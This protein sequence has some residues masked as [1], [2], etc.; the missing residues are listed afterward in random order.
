MAYPEC[1]RITK[2]FQFSLALFN[3][4]VQAARTARIERLLV[5]LVCLVYLVCLVD[6]TGNSSRRIRQTRKTGQ[7]DR[8]ARARC[9]C[10]RMTRLPFIAR[11]ERCTYSL[12][13]CSFSLQGWSLID[14]P[15]RASNEGLRRPRVARAQKIIRAPSPPL[16]REHRTNVGVLPSFD[17]SLGEWPRLPFTERIERAHSYRARSASKKDTWPLPAHP[18]E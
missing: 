18:S 12:Q 2:A 6:Q 4:V 16:F 1:S 14:L 8:R 11:I 15:L 5:H 13:A 9:A 3:G 7:P 17:L 10:R